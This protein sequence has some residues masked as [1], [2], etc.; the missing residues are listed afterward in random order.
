MSD[1]QTPPLCSSLKIVD[2][3]LV[4][5]GGE[6]VRGLLDPKDKSYRMNNKKILARPGALSDDA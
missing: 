4:L 6:R 2:G 1:E 5:K 3:A